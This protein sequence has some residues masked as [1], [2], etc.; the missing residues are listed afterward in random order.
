M[1]MY[2]G[3]I[4]SN[5]NLEHDSTHLL[6]LQLL[7]Q[8]VRD[9]SAKPETWTPPLCKLDKGAIST[10]RLYKD[11]SIVLFRKPALPRPASLSDLSHLRASPRAGAY[12]NNL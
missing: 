8:Q 4:R 3:S 2:W 5:C 1:D 10:S 7:L 12:E 9:P 6:R 11:S